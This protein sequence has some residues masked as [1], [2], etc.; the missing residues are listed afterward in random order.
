MKGWGGAY[1]AERGIFNVFILFKRYRTK[2]KLNGFHFH[3]RKTSG[4]D[5]KQGCL[6]KTEKDGKIL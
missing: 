3:T 1:L 6:T 2:N 5:Y 4:H